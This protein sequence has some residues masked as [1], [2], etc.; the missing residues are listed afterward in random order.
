MR[1]VPSDIIS[2]RPRQLHLALPVAVTVLILPGCV[3]QEIHEDLAATRAGV[4]RIAEL[5]PALR[6]TNAALDTSN[7]QLE[8]LYGELASTHQSLELVLA[9][10]D[11]TNIHMQESVRQLRHLDPM[12]VSLKSL[13]E[14][15]AALR[16]LVDNLD[17]VVPLLRL[18]KGTSPV[19]GTLNSER[20]E[21]DEKQRLPESQLP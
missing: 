10:L 16:K 4:E 20:T 15:L 1:A 21:P 7:A 2:R 12:M 9:R 5:A 8:R 17:R 14:S 6:Q 18:S 19:E 13:D 3:V 11:T